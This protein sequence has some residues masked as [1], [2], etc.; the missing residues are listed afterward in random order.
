MCGARCA[1]GPMPIPDRDRGRCRRSGY[2]VL[3]DPFHPWWLATVDGEPA[4][5]LRADAIFRAVRVP[6]GRHLVQFTFAP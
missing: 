2:L 3:R 5:V 4:P 1:S 6:A